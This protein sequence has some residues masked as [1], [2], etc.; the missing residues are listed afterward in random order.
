MQEQNSQE[1]DFV[2]CLVGTAQ[3][4]V[5]GP[6]DEN[7]TRWAA[8]AQQVHAA[9]KTSMQ[10]SQGQHLL[11]VAWPLRILET[12]T[13]CQ[14]FHPEHVQLVQSYHCHVHAIFAPE[15]LAWVQEQ[16]H[17]HALPL[18]QAGFYDVAHATNYL[19]PWP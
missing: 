18:P 10:T 12:R 5:P 8:V 6:V 15:E 9:H 7:R 2:Q 13:A 17:Q 3:D 19:T 1:Q 16:S 14:N 4:G 11:L